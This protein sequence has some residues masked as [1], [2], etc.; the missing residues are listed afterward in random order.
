M[1]NLSSQTLCYF[2]KEE[3]NPGQGRYRFFQD[4]KEIECCPSCFDR[5]GAFPQRRFEETAG[6]RPV[7]GSEKCGRDASDQ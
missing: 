2:C 4:D 6:V 1:T 7:G 5:T 3:L